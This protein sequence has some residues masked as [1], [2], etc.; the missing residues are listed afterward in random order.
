MKN[1]KNGNK[2]DSSEKKKLILDFIN[3]PLKE[4]LD[5][6]NISFGRFKEKINETFGTDFSYCD[7]YPSYLFNAQIFYEEQKLF[8]GSNLE[9]G[10]KS[11]EEKIDKYHALCKEIIPGTFIVCGEGYGNEKQ[12]CSQACLNKAKL[13]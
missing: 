13:G 6:G 5:G 2:M 7:L 3:G 11:H 10:R 4:Y 9:E 12:Y 1:I 8:D